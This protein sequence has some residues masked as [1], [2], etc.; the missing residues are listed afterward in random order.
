MGHLPEK[1][2]YACDRTN[3]IVPELKR[4]RALENPTDD[5]IRQLVLL[6]GEFHELNPF[7]RFAWVDARPV[8]DIYVELMKLERRMS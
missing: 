3:E 1:I 2:I 6:T 8:I 5:D 7:H 4:L